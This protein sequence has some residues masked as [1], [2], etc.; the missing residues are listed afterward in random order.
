M[1]NAWVLSASW[2]DHSLPTQ[3]MVSKRLART[4]VGSGHQT[5]KIIAATRLITTGPFV[6]L[7]E[8]TMWSDV[9]CCEDKEEQKYD[10]D[11]F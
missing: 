6:G 1:P 5:R 4:T 9:T 10:G 11:T 2:L 8:E 3:P 7:A